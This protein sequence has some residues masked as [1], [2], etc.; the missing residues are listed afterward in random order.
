MQLSFSRLTTHPVK[1]IEQL[2]EVIMVNT[3]DEHHTGLR[4]LLIILNAIAIL[5]SV[6][7]ARV[8][9]FVAL[10]FLVP[11]LILNALVFFCHTHGISLSRTAPRGYS[12]VGTPATEIDEADE[13]ATAST[14]GKAESADDEN[15][16]DRWKVFVTFLDTLISFFCLIFHFVVGVISADGWGHSVMMGL[17]VAMIFMICA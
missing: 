4:L 15:H 9:L 14:S 10:C 13:A 17:D 6:V 11:F 12:R 5:L 8:V 1:E 16:T 7:G 3:S 2:E